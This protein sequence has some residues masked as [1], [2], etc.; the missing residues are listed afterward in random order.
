MATA[1]MDVR[2]WNEDA[3]RE[4]ILQERESRCRTVFRTAFAP[5]SDRNPNPN[6]IPDVIVAASSDGSLASY[7]I[8]SFLSSD[9]LLIAEPDCFIQAHEGAAYDIKFHENGEDSLL[10]SCGDDGH[11]RGWRWKEMTA[12]TGAHLNPV[13]DLVNLQHKGPWG[14]LSPIPETN[15]IA[16]D[17]QGQS[18]Y[19]AAGN[20]CAYC[21]D[22]ETGK[23]KVV[24]K[25][26]SDYLHSVV[27][28]N[29]S[30]QVLTGSEDG[31]TRIWDSVS[32]KC[33]R[34]LSM[35][36]NDKLKDT[37]CVSSLALDASE[38]WLACGSGR[39]LFIW[40]LVAG[41]RVSRIPTCTSVQD[42]VFHGNQVIAVGAEPLVSRYD[43][44]G[45]I[46]S[47][48]QCAPHSVFSISL[49]SSG[50]LAAAGY[51]GL[52]DVISPFGSHLC[53]LHCRL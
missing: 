32:G 17:N 35:E 43:M 22:V 19:A 13:V 39:S 15:A 44:S 46:R 52:V 37:P 31:T 2:S 47:Q 50:V 9:R 38:S 25:G 28:R 3:Y 45:E 33:I 5:S 42:V 23:V 29:S 34:V 1:T 40:N 21:W 20:S 6:S 8:S 10:F 36:K 24:Y 30:N 41:E 53:V 12:V 4:T 26:H 51:G 7:S 16:L 11:I 49:H 48:I 27:V 14:S 18:I